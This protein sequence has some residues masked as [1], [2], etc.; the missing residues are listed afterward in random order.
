MKLHS[1]QVLFLLNRITMPFLKRHQKNKSK[2]FNPWIVVKYFKKNNKVKE[3]NKVD[4]MDNPYLIIFK[5]KL[6]E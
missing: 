1:K 6:N 3:A 2:K 5:P 4:L